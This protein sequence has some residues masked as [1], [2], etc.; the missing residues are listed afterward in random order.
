MKPTGF[1]VCAH[2]FARV[3]LYAQD[4]TGLIVLQ[5][6]APSMLQ[7]QQWRWMLLGL[8]GFAVCA[9]TFVRVNFFA[10]DHTL[11][12]P[13]VRVVETGCQCWALL[14]GAGCAW[15]AGCARGGNR[16]PG[17]GCARVVL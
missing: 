6:V 4:H 5:I 12:F 7:N 11:L 13:A 9:R 14:L 17:A 8:T 1:A 10:Q 16:V 2:T 15:S 3:N